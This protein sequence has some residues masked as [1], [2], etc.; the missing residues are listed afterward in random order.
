MATEF[1]S[2]Q[3]LTDHVKQT[4][5]F[6]HPGCVDQSGGFYHTFR[7]DGRICDRETR[8]LVSS[9]RFVFI[10]SLY[11]NRFSS[12]EH[13]Q[14]ARHGVNYLRDFH[15]NPETGGYAWL[16]KNHVVLDDTNHCYGLAFVLLSY[17]CAAKA[18][19]ES[20]NEY[21]YETFDLME[22]HFWLEQHGLYGDECDGSWSTM[23]PY[24]GQ[25]S[26]MH[27]CEAMIAAYEATADRKF[28]ERA[29]LIAENICIRQAA[30]SGDLI[31]E[32]FDQNWQVDWEYNRAD[33]RNVLRPWG[34]QTG[35]WTEWAKLLLILDRY[36]EETWL[37]GRAIEL[38]DAAVSKAWDRENGGL[39]YGIGPD[40]VL[41]DGDKYFWVQAESIAAAARLAVATGDEKYW[42][43][44]EKLWQ[45]SWDHMIDHTYGGWFCLLSQVNE[46]YSDLKSP[47]GKTD[48]H[49][50]GACYDTLSIL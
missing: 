22:Q 47:L 23:S 7:D 15:R 33:P 30:L 13:K 32:H 8:H 11:A 1:R 37:L 16:L 5:A 20:A 14:L 35:H 12:N 44:Y 4:M 3:F 46:K 40:G 36:L 42:R 2:K 26:N 25:N 10:Y 39:V 29:H 38:F 45:Y 18:G 6:Y 50:M 27:N 48:Y 34:F 49:S 21:I 41:C 9:S 28:L 17:S 43:W 24:R 31:W 19:I